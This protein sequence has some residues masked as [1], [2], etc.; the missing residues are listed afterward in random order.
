MVLMIFL[1]GMY[2]VLDTFIEVEKIKMELAVG[3]AVHQAKMM[4]LVSQAQID[5]LVKTSE[6]RIRTLY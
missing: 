5:S 2:A 6:S 1:I 4:V 3:T